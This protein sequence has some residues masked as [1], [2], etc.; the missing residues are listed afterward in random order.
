MTILVTGGAG[1]IG[2]HMVHELVDRGE[3]VAVLD[4]LS[5]GF[6]WAIP[7]HVPLIEGDTGD[8]GLAR[9]LMAE[10][11]VTAVIHFA[12]SVVVPDSVAD[13]LGYYRNNTANS[14][15]L[16]EA[17]VQAGVRDFIFSST[18]AVYGN[19]AAVPV[20]EDAPLAPMS[21]YG[22]SKMM[23]EMMLRDASAAHDLRHVILR[24]FN[25]AGADPQLRTGQ[26]TRGAT[27]LIKVAV[28]TAL[29][30]RPKIDVYGT[31]YPTPDGT[32]IR[33]YIHVTDLV[34]AHSDALR[35]LRGGGGSVTLNCGY[36]R[37]FSVLEVIETVKKVAGVDFRV[38]RGAPRAG[39]PARI[40]AAC[41]R[42]RTLLGW[43]P[44][45]DD[46]STIVTHALAWER[47]LRQRRD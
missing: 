41:E 37:G 12:A 38:E 34:R 26:S 27:H 30:I 45:L 17:A 16:I 23:T 33:D 18:A 19:P 43:K 39:D 15:T 25:V 28:E 5:T 13:P 21:P 46:L 9:S 31:D 42:A 8:A 40:V 44:Q 7:D 22:A 14:R 6:R 36:G 2:S 24:Y 35:Y 4:N 1:Y 32:C 3:S 47:K 20:A 11:G 29:G 10:H